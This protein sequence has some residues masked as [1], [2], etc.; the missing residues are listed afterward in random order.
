MNAT[1]YLLSKNGSSSPSTKELNGTGL[2]GRAQ[3]NQI[4]RFLKVLGEK[5]SHKVA[6][7][8]GDFLGYFEKHHS[9]SKSL[10]G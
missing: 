1:A 6:Q 5:F 7:M 4:G 8:R 10:C 9:S 3:C 2:S